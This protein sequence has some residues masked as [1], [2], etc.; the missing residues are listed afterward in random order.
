MEV[1]FPQHSQNKVTSHHCL[2]EL[3]GTSIYKCWKTFYYKSTM[4]CTIAMNRK[5]TRTGDVG[6][7]PWLS[8]EDFDWLS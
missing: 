4:Y 1:S 5:L 8:V 7:N 6:L 2:C 3:A